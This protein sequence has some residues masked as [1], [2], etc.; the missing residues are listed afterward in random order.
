[1]SEPP[2]STVVHVRVVQ[3]DAASADAVLTAISR[4]FDTTQSPASGATDVEQALSPHGTLSVETAG[5]RFPLDPAP[6][7]PG[8]SGPATI[9]LFGDIDAV[10]RVA[11]VLGAEFSIEQLA[12]EQATLT[13]AIH[14][15]TRP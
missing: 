10:D 15:D 7:A 4:T 14:P 5:R 12:D 6:L 2:W 1:M 8:G 9:A 13:L 11:A 3:A